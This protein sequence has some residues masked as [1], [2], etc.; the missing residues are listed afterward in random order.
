MQRNR[1]GWRS[2]ANGRTDI[3]VQRWMNWFRSVAEGG[4]IE[5]CGEMNECGSVAAAMINGGSEHMEANGN[6]RGMRAAGKHQR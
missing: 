6:G 2:I 4:R 5:R 1:D 3:S